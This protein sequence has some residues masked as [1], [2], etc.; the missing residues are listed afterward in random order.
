LI[1][2][3]KTLYEA[4]GASVTVE[5]NDADVL[6]VS[7]TDGTPIHILELKVSRKD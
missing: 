6:T 5:I 2:V 1:V 4:K 7:D 3:A